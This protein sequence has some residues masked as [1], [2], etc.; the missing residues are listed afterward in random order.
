LF[1]LEPFPET[2]VNQRFERWRTEQERT[3]VI[4]T[5]AQMEWL[6]MIKDHIASSLGI[7]M[8]DFE[9][10]P[11]NQKGGAVKALQLFGNR[12]NNILEELNEVLAV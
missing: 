2:A 12:L 10:V 3:G 1:V 8:E 4:F 7:G 11:F 9:S 5:E 6:V